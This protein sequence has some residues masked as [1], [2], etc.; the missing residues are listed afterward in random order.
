M[1]DETLDH[2]LFLRSLASAVTDEQN[3]TVQCYCLQIQLLPFCYAFDC[4]WKY[5]FMLIQTF[6]CYIFSY[7][8]I[9]VIA[10]CWKSFVKIVSKKF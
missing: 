8:T 3:A 7:R 6:V 1:I 4:Q 9:T 5:Q 10:K 2:L